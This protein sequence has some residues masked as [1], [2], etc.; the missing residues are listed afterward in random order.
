MFLD[1][2]SQWIRS[3][4]MIGVSALAVVL[5]A[6]VAEL[7]PNW[8]RIRAMPAEQRTKLLQNLRKFELELSPEKQEVIRE[9]DRQI[10][11]LDPQQ[12]ARYFWVLRRYHDWL[13]SL[14]EN[15]QDELL[16]QPPEGRKAMIRKLVEQYAV[17]TSETPEFLRIAEVGE[18]SPFELASAFRIWQ[19]ANASQREHLERIPAG[20]KRRD[21][22]LQLGSRLKPAIPRETKPADFD[23]EDWI[24]RVEEFW[25]KTR[26]VMLF[27]GAAANKGDEVAKNKQDAVRQIY[28]RQA[29]NLYTSRNKIQAVDSDRLKQFLTALPSWLQNAVDPYPP[30]EARSTTDLGL[31]VGFPLPRR[32]RGVAKSLGFTDQGGIPHHSEEDRLDPGQ[33]QTGF[34]PGP[35]WPLLR[36][37]EG[38]DSG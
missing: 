3:C 14:P 17:P 25:R 37:C 36:G 30:D 29:V 10:A 27:N 26:P 15:K 22:L 19:A 35:G 1:K 32:D 8:A 24:G 34:D 11:K 18:L 4:G 23:E 16:G 20:R 7:D 2:K 33:A 12:R 5:V 31:P 13:N 9:L 38:I 21:P 28:R 6:A